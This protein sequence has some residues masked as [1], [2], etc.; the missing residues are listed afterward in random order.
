MRHRWRRVLS[1]LLCSHCCSAKA[2]ELTARFFRD[3]AG[4]SC[5]VAISHV[6]HAGKLPVMARFCSTAADNQ[7]FLVCYC[8]ASAIWLCDANRAKA[9]ATPI[10]IDRGSCSQR[11]SVLPL[12]RT[13]RQRQVRRLKAAHHHHHQAA[14]SNGASATPST[15]RYARCVGNASKA[16]R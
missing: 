7:C 12:V 2:V 1:P 9:V 5:A 11:S 16:V 8:G 15:M 3:W 4:R 10:N 14:W 13:S 6:S